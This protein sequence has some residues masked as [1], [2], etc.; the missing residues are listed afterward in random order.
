MAP[1]DVVEALM[2][3]LEAVQVAGLAIEVGAAAFL[4]WILWKTIKQAGGQYRRTADP[5]DG[6]RRRVPCLDFVEDHQTSGRTIPSHRGC[7][8]W[9]APGFVHGH[10]IE[11]NASG[12]TAQHHPPPAAAGGVPSLM[13]LLELDRRRDAHLRRSSSR[14]AMRD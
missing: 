10:R 2:D 8:R 7:S 5:R 4:V 1:R 11:R 12:A 9:L 3:L 14:R 6:W 13:A